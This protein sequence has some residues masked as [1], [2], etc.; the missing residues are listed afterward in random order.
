MYYAS[1]H[2]IAYPFTSTKHAYPITSRNKTFWE[3]VS[4][5]SDEF[6]HTPLRNLKIQH[7]DQIVKAALYKIPDEDIITNS[8]HIIQQNN[9]TNTNLNTL[10]KQLTLNVPDTPQVSSNIST[11]TSQINTI[12]NNQTDDIQTSDEDT[13]REE[14]PKIDKLVCRNPK[15]LASPD[16]SIQNETNNINQHKFHTSSLYEWNIDRMLEYLILNTLQ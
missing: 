5:P 9:F 6:E 7:K 1:E 12:Q 11:S 10:S 4:G 14:T 13:F 15:S 2:Y 16:I 8:K 3:L